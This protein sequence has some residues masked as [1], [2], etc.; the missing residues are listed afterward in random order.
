[1]YSN[2]DVINSNFRHLK[3]AVSFGPQIVEKDIEGKLTTCYGYS[4][5]LDT[6]NVSYINDIKKVESVRVDDYDLHQ[7]EFDDQGN[8]I[9]LPIVGLEFSFS[10]K[11]LDGQF[12]EMVDS[13]RTEFQQ[14]A[15]Y[16]EADKT[17]IFI[18]FKI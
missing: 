1:M 10:A 15:E 9:F 16:Q 4:V 8:P 11:L 6:E 17:L 2:S 12:S 3:S 7:C 14:F 13:I 5:T 18:D